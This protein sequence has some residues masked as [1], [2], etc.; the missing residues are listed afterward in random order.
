VFFLKNFKLFFWDFDGVIKESIKVKTQ[1]YFKL[2]EPFGLDVAEKVRQHH[3]I[4]AGIS[5]FDKMPL[6]LQWAGL[7]PTKFHVDEYCEQFSYKV[8]QGVIDAPWVAGVEEYLRTNPHKQDFVL[9]SA[10]P[11]GELERILHALDLTKCFVDIYGA[12]TPKQEAIRKMLHARD[13]D[14]SNSLMIGDAQ[15]DLDAATVNQVPFLLR[16]HSDNSRVFAN[17]TGP[18]VENFSNL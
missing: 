12:P 15:A 13:I 16:R 17:Y 5:R 9:T 3:E 8:L 14:P 6:Y 7:T 2:F 1:A 4:N 11:Q 10:T 18:F